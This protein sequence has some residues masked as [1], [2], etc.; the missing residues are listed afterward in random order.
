MALFKKTLDYLMQSMIKLG[1]A[2]LEL[3]GIGVDAFIIGFIIIGL[4]K[5]RTRMDIHMSGHVSETP[6][7]QVSK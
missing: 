3:D 5:I 4:R 1:Q 6:E 7:E 2:F